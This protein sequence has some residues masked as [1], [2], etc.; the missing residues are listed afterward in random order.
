[1]KS[2]PESTQSSVA[3]LLAQVGAHAA[4]H[5]AQRLT[6][7]DLLPQH[8]GILRMLAHTSGISQQDLAL[9]LNM[10]ASRLVGL[11]DTLEKRGLIERQSSASDRRVYALHLTEPGRQTLR[12]LGIIARA[13]DDATCEGLS[14]EERAHLFS[15]LERVAQQQGLTHGVHPGYRAPD[16]PGTSNPA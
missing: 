2:A 10:H 5:F 8:A 16:R 7:L 3:F 1:M 13:H 6:P 14:Q 11:V 4:N 12:Q 15:L 9:K